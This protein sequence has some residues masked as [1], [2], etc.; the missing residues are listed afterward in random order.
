[1]KLKLYSFVSLALIIVCVVLGV[2]QDKGAKPKF[3]HDGKI[4]STYDRSQSQTV[5]AFSPY[6]VT[7]NFRNPNESIAITSGFI[8]SGQSLKSKPQF[9]EFGVLSQSSSGWEFEKEKDRELTI[10]IDG[11]SVV[12]GS[13]KL[14]TARRY[15]LGGD[16]YY[17]EDLALNVPYEG[18]M[19]VANAKKVV[20]K[21][22]RKELKLK[23]EHH[24]IMR[25]LLSRA[26]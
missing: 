13:M 9:I 11:E 23:N 24:E 2:A 26:G 20:I 1:M 17:R 14:I 15:Q 19:R 4:Q 12:L 21:V 25:E 3:K 16:Q 6:V 22:G 10:T 18:F 5:V 7:Y 8:F